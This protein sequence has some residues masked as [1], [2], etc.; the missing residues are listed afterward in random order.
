MPSPRLKTARVLPKGE[1]RFT[2]FGAL[3]YLSQNNERV[4][5]PYSYSTSLMHTQRLGSLDLHAQGRFGWIQVT[6]EG[7]RVESSDP[8]TFLA[9]DNARPPNGP[10]ADAQAGGRIPLCR[11]A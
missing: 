10:F 11:Q 1:A 3:A 5:K 8:T 7:R 4:V 2:Q 9:P 6:E